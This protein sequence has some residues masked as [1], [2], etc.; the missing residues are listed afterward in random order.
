MAEIR[1]PSVKIC[2]A[3]IAILRGF[4]A[5]KGCIMTPS[6]DECA[7]PL[8]EL[9]HKWRTEYEWWKSQGV[10]RDQRF[11][12]AISRDKE[13]GRDGKGNRG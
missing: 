10:F 12:V 1:F 2:M 9:E 13:G 4:D 3:S 5:Y 6:R 11:P 7:G 8:S